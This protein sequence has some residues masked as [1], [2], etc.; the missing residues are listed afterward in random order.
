[1]RT[2]LRGVL[3]DWRFIHGLTALGMFA[4][5]GTVAVPNRR[6]AL[7]VAAS[8][9]GAACGTAI[10]IIDAVRDPGTPDTGW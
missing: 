10:R 4:L 1:M 3:K 2:P 6:L 5:W 7:A 9:L 8:W